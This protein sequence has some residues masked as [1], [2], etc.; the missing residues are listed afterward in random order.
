MS[1]KSLAA[2]AGEYI[3]S[4]RLQSQIINKYNER[5]R[6]ALKS[7]NRDELLVCSRA[8][9]VLYSARRDLLETADLLSSYYD[10]S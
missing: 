3:E 10:R 2:L 5:K 9:A 7:R 1:T 4:A 6:E 8:L